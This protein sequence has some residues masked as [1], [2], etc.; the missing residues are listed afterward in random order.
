MKSEVHNTTYTPSQSSFFEELIQLTHLFYLRENNFV[1]DLRRERSC[2]TL[3]VMKKTVLHIAIFSLLATSCGP[4]RETI[5]PNCEI[6]VGEYSFQFPQDFELIKEKG[7]DSYVGKISN[8]EI[9]F[10][11]D[12]GYYS[13]SLDK[14]ID[15]YLS[16]D[17]WKWNAL[18]RSNLLPE[19]DITGIAERTE[20]I[21]YN[22][23]D[24]IHYTMLFL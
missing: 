13:N 16:D 8:G 2:K 7:V 14:S 4:N 6:E 20:L 19:G 15:E 1:P 12:Y 22:T 9:D 21:S 23:S 11:F 18:G 17:V 3:W 5:A 24:S 10:Q